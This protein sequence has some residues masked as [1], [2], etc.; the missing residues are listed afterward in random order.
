MKRSRS[1]RYSDRSDYEADEA[2]PS[3]STP[4]PVREDS[5]QYDVFLSFRGPDTRNSFTGHLYH[6]VQDKGIH[7]FI[8]SEELEKGQK[9]EE[10]FGYIERFQI[11]VSI[12]SKGYA[13]SEWCLKEI[14]KMV[15][16]ERLI[17]PVFFDVEPRE[18]VVNLALS[19]LH[20]QD[21][22]KMEVVR[23]W[24]D[25]LTAAGKFVGDEAT[26]IKNIVKRILTEVNRAPL[27]IGSTHP[28]GIDSRI[29]ELVEVLEVEA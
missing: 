5:F 10:L 3:S 21:I 4:Q 29:A 17:I 8:D 18:V 25:A 15:E 9:V 28:I 19:H 27:F 20:S 14:S 11:F 6:T 26:Q 7:T 1:P 13:D 23:K 16:S 24:S 12:F 2:A 22:L